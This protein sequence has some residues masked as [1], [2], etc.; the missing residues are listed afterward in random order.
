MIRKSSSR[1][2]WR[3]T[4]MRAAILCTLALGGC[5]AARPA[6]VIAPEPGQLTLRFRA[7]NSTEGAV[8]VRLDGPAIGAIVA[9]QDGTLA[10]SRMDGSRREI[11]VVGE[12][13]SGAI[14]RFDVPDINRV[15][16]YSAAIVEVA[17]VDNSLR[18][19]LDEYSIQVVR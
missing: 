18:D 5:D 1:I 12:W 8:R 4:S 6:E 17:G 2:E 3:K 15:E 19:D 7:S 11:V 14:V 10:F 16:K 9:V 13:K